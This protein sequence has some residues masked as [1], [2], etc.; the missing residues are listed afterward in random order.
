MNLNKRKNLLIISL[1]VEIIC[2]SY[3]LILGEQAALVSILYLITGLAF[4]YLV[5]LF[6]PARLRPAREIK[7]DFRLKLVIGIVMLLLAYVTS[8]YWLDL[9]PIDPDFADMLPIMKVMNERLLHG[10]WKQVYD[11]VQEIW[12]GT[13]PIYLPAMW[14]PYAPAV[15]LH[16]DMRWV[17]VIS[18]LLSFAIILVFVRVKKNGY[19]GYGL[20]VIGAIL[21]W[22]LFSRNEVHSLITMS[23]E[24]VVIFYFVLLCLSIISENALLMGL[25]ASLCL[26]S[27]YSMIGWLIPCLIYFIARKDFRRLFIFSVTGI[28]CFL[29]FFLIPFGWKTLEQMAALPGNYIAFAKHV[30]DVSPEV[31][32]LNPGMAKFYGP[33]H[34]EGLHKTLITLSFGVPVLF[35]AYCFIQ[36]NQKFENINLACFKLSLLVFYQFIDV[37]Y[38]YLFYTSSFVSLL[39]AA[40]LLS[41]NARGT[42]ESLAVR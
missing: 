34:I 33:H 19:Y 36:K 10:N 31:Y 30:W 23:E 35:M 8:S 11:P 37:P 24:G 18:L 20:I 2:A 22:W 4:V 3:G 13:L 39:I 40:V 41:G 42:E 17:T 6:P 9:I 38:G 16:V 15:A 29:L 21:F 28:F 1:A 32:W 5:L 7:N 14:I 12:N 26:L 25:T 27:R